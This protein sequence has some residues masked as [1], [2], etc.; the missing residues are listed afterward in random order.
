MDDPLIRIVVRWIQEWKRCYLP[1]LGNRFMSNHAIHLSFGQPTET[2]HVRTELTTLGILILLAT[3]IV[4]PNHPPLYILGY[5][6]PY[7]NPFNDTDTFDQL[8]LDEKI[9]REH[10]AP[11][12]LHPS[13]PP[14]PTSTT[15]YYTKCHHY[16]PQIPSL[17]SHYDVF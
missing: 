5:P 9:T 11:I 10:L 12:H 14:H 17:R 6:T 8:D 1:F 7:P 15:T 16:H 2:I 4:V 13:T 3:Y